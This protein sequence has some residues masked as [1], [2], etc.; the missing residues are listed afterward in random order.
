MLKRI[1]FFIFII[2]ILCGLTAFSQQGTPLVTNFTFGETSIDN[3][4]WSMAQDCE[5]QMMF[6]NRRGIVSFDGMK[7]N[8][9]L[10]PSAPLSLYFDDDSGQIFVGCKNNIGLLEK[11]E[12][13]IY[14]YVSLVISGRSVG[15]I[16]VITGL[17]GKIYFYST[18]YIS[19]F[20]LETKKLKQWCAEPGEPYTGFFTNKQDV[21]VNVDK[22]GLH[23]LKGE[24]KSPV[25]G[26]EK[27]FDTRIK[28]FFKYS[29]SQ[30]LIG[31]N[32]DSLYMF[33]GSKLHPFVIESNKYIQESILAGGIN[34]DSKSFVLSTITGGCLIVDKKTR[35][36]TYTLNYQTGLP[37]DE[38][39]S[40][41]IDQ[42]HGLWLLHEYGMS[43]V[44]LRLPIRNVNHY[45]G[46]EGN[47]TSI[48]DVDSS[49]YVSTS[50]G[51]YY[52][53]EIKNYE[54]IEIL[55]KRNDTKREKEDIYTS[56]ELKEDVSIKVKPDEIIDEKE[57]KKRK[58]L[59]QNF[60]KEKEEKE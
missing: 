60:Q 24:S 33:S 45:P 4:S 31:T 3:E 37:D 48:I 23:V 27:L 41:G 5:G 30:V 44:D 14:K 1:N 21:Y 8:T 47:L 51:V 32:K 42:N 56:A 16:E 7:W 36:T 26:G 40:M 59:E 18:Q 38:I 9:I 35:K 49:I 25:R 2:S 53:S 6:A 50:E 17:N 57:K 10:T 29:K 28:F 52:L 39:Y 11:G 12:D 22:L 13:G 58:D 43:R 20:D 46:L 34:I 55:V 54:E 15:D 19:C